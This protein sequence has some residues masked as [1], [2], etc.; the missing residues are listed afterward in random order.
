[1]VLISSSLSYLQEDP[2]LNA[3]VSHALPELQKLS[4]TQI[5]KLVFYLKSL[6]GYY[7]KSENHTTYSSEFADKLD[8]LRNSQEQLGFQRQTSS[9]ILKGIVFCVLGGVFIAVALA[10]L[11]GGQTGIGIGF[12]AVTGACV[13][14]ADAKFFRKAILTSKEQDRKYFLSSIRA[15]NACNELDWAGLFSYNKASK[16]GSLSD[17]DVALLAAQVAELTE[18]LRAALYNDEYFQYSS[19]NFKAA[20]PCDG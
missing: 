14:L 18:R 1:V 7:P 19:A 10:A 6:H 5:E 16:S 3:A 17:D 20:E 8:R 13:I 9:S 2:K 12:F 11:V 4:S 15:A